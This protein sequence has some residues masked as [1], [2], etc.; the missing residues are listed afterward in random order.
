MIWGL[1]IEWRF[2]DPLQESAIACESKNSLSA[3]AFIG[4]LFSKGLLA[5]L[6]QLSNN[7][8]RCG[9]CALAALESDRYHQQP[10]RLSSSVGVFL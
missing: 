10:R 2:V 1:L 7:V 3:E 9:F 4:R 6:S 5:H 8:S